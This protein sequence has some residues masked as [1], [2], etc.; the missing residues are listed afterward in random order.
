MNAVLTR[1]IPLPRPAWLS[2]LLLPVLPLLAATLHDQDGL[3]EQSVTLT[4]LLLLLGLALA[5]VAPLVLARAGRLW[6]KEAEQLRPAWLAALFTAPAPLL[7]GGG[8]AAQFALMFFV[9]TCALVAAVP[10]GMEFQQR[11]LA[12][13]LS[14][15]VERR[16]LWRIKTAVLAAALLTHAAAFT[17]ALGVTGARR[18][19]EGWGLIPLAVAVA[20]GTTPWWTLLT[21]SLIAG[22]V[23]SLAAPL[24]T[25]A[26][27]ALAVDLMFAGE[28]LSAAARFETWAFRGALWLAAPVYALA[29]ARLGCRRWLG[30]EAIE[31]DSATVTGLFRRRSAG[32]TTARRRSAW[33]QLA[34]KE[35]RLHAV[36][37]GV[38]G[39]AVLFALVTLARDWS[40][41]TREALPIFTAML[42]ALAVLLA[43]ATCIA[44]ERRLGTLDGQLLQ[45]VSRARQWWLKLLLAA[46]PAA[47][48]VF[49]AVI[50]AAGFRG[51]TQPGEAALANLL[52]VAGLASG[53]F[54]AAVLASSASANALRALIA[55]LVIFFAGA[56]AI[57]GTMTLLDLI[58]RTTIFQPVMETWQTGRLA[59]GTDLL[60]RAA[61][62]TPAELEGLQATTFNPENRFE[63]WVGLGMA[64]WV[65]VLAAALTLAWRNFVSPAGASGRLLRQSVVVIG[66]LAVCV[67]A[68]GAWPLRQVAVAEERGLLLH[69]R[70]HL[71]W[72]EQLPPA[73]RELYRRHASGRLYQS[74]SVPM[75]PEAASDRSGTGLLQPARR[76]AAKSF[77]LPLKPADL[78]LLLERG[79]L[80]A[81]LREA[82]RREAEP[83][84]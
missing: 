11:T 57:G 79:D 52:I 47:L 5:V 77:N 30:L 50:A 38:C 33:L 3:K 27:L 70:H 34:G 37:W 58:Q 25:L 32:R 71:A 13:L 9:A 61:A 69:A 44:D 21:R 65:T 51:L 8:D 43:G 29:G 23:F 74:V 64:V 14:Q 60:E 68:A 1:E 73:Q 16:D 7:F 67:A 55:G 56:L 81:D 31:G 48:A 76:S 82:L 42:A 2:P 63:F 12:G 15:P 22:L 41:G 4:L 26:L 20:L 28:E 40:P 78:A 6:R 24:V 35:V 19:A 59:D 54:V 83:R 62:L 84:R 45:P 10:F 80:P 75:N 66:V 17:L 72:R 53:G 46:A 36:T 39:L 18:T 49:A